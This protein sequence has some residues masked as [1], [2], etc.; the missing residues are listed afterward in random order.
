MTSTD[1]N[2]ALNGR[3]TQRVHRRTALKTIGAAAILPFMGRASATGQIDTL[4][5][6]PGRSTVPENLGFSA[7]GDL[8]FSLIRTGELRRLPARRTDETGLTLADTEL[9]A[10]FAGYPNERVTGVAVGGSTPYF[11][12]V[13][14]DERS[15]VY[16]VIDDGPEQL[17]TISGFPNGVLYDRIHDRLLVTDSLGDAVYAVSLPDGEAEIWAQSPLLDTPEPGVNGLTWGPGGD[18]F[19]VVM[20][21]GNETG[22]LVR[23]P[24]CVDGSAAKATTYVESPTLFGADGIT[25]RGPHIYAAV[26][27]QNTIVRVTPAKKLLT[28]IEGEPL[29]RPSDVLFGVAPGQRGN[30]FICNY[31]PYQPKQ[32]T[33]LRTHP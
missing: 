4:L 28:I 17:A 10:N 11:A 18:L 24:V 6:F 7:D 25:A 8:Y 19:V 1:D 21:T 31:S 13:T 5:A 16:A 22:R 32:A 15:G 30:L 12:L 29:A 26:N 20:D 27:Y 33:I 2:R 14:D 9:I 23:I 3:T